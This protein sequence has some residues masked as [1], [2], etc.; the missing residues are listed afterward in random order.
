MQL[1]KI[2]KIIIIKALPPGALKAIF[3]LLDSFLALT[4]ENSV[5]IIV[6]RLKIAPK[7]TICSVTFGNNAIIIEIKEVIKAAK[8]G[9]PFPLF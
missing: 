2:I 7:F 9:T 8:A 4:S 6:K 3:L 5:I 1:I